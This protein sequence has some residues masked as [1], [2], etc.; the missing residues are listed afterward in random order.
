[1]IIQ[2][3]P[4]KINTSFEN[5]TE[6]FSKVSEERKT[7]GYR[8]Y[9]INQRAVAALNLPNL[10]FYI[11]TVKIA[12][13]RTGGNVSRQF[14]YFGGRWNR[15]AIYRNLAKLKRMGFI[16]QDQDRKRNWQPVP[17][18]RRYYINEAILKHVKSRQD[19]LYL[20]YLLFIVNYRGNFDT[21]TH[22]T[23]K[24]AGFAANTAEFLYRYIKDHLNGSRLEKLFNAVV[25]AFRLIRRG[26]AR[27]VTWIRGNK[28]VFKFPVNVPK[29]RQPA[30]RFY[31][32]SLLN[33]K[34]SNAPLWSAGPGTKRAEPARKTAG[35]PADATG[36]EKTPCLQFG[37]STG[38]VLR[39][40]GTEEKHQL[41]LK[42]IYH[43]FA[44]PEDFQAMYRTLPVSLQKALKDKKIFF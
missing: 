18:K 26:T 44:G 8:Y 41:P 22:R 6:W 42:D 3:N 23:I 17:G 32:R 4:E 24:A 33:T 27:V 12:N 31:I 7:P 11:R 14:K 36:P 15:A 43:S 20:K 30:G 38:P 16:R 37:T 9:K 28:P 2:Q 1:M 29:R 13:F 34:S 25:W 5:L 19:T 40:A 10:H 39:A 35:P 21:I